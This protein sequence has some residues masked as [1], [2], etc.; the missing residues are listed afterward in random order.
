M[1]VFSAIAAGIGS[2]L[3]AVGTGIS[4]ALGLGGSAAGA[5]SGAAGAA[6]AAAGGGSALAGL[7]GLAGIVGT[8]VSAVG[9][10]Q[11]QAAMKKA[12]KIRSRQMSLEAMRAQ[13]QTLRE[14][15][16]ARAAAL[17]NAT[18]QG[19]GGGSGIQGGMAQIAGQQNTNILGINQGL[20]LGQGMFAANRQ[21]AAGQTMS[22]IGSGIQNFGSFL[23]QNQQTMNRLYPSIA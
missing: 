1:A 22:S 10:F 15:Q 19:A 5:A 3:S 13:R 12:E 21:L 11:Q 4:S 9:Q 16:I 23:A 7:S 17:S 8:G 20:S 18:A 6:G 2:A 14:A